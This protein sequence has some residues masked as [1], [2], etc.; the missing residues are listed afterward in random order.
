ILTVVENFT[1]YLAGFPLLRKDDTTDVLINLLENENKRLGYFPTW[2]CSDGGGEFIASRLVRFLGSKNIR[3]LISEPY[4]PEHNGRAERANRTIVESIRATFESSGVKK[5]LWPELLKSCCLM[6]NSIPWKGSFESPWKLMHGKDLP[7]GFIKPIGTPA[8]TVNHWR[9]KGRKFSLKGE[10]GVLVGFDPILLSYRILSKSGA[11]IKSKHVRFLK[12]PDVV[13]SSNDS[14][15]H[16]SESQRFE[17]TQESQHKEIPVV[18]LLNGEENSP[19][20]QANQFNDSDDCEETEVQNQLV[21]P[22][23]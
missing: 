16:P 23:T 19:D 6:L 22:Q 5:S 20:D 13:I 4:H 11:V 17:V 14:F 8:I 3:R 15:D 9:V 1:G 2:V 10:E 7:Q 18:E 12:K 21:E